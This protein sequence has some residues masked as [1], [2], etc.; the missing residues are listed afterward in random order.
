VT[1]TSAE[2]LRRARALSGLSQ[3]ELARRAGVSQP[4]ISAY[5]RG[6]R[7]PGLSTLV[8]LVNATGCDVSIEVKPTGTKAGVAPIESALRRRVRRRRKAIESAAARR[9]VRNVRLFGSVARGDDS[10]ASDVDFLVDLDDGVSLVDLIG[11]ERELTQLLGCEVDVVPA[12]N[13][14]PEV[15]QRVLAEATPP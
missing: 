3:S 7:E 2:V 8:K 13:V 6:R 11:L 9:G 12:R 14:K 5:E 4:V 15:A 10:D 1:D